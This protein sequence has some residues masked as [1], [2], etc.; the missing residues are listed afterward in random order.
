M[1]YFLLFRRYETAN[2][3]AIANSA[4]NPAGAG[5]GHEGRFGVVVGFVGVRVG[6]GVAVGAVT[7]GVTVILPVISM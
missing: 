4:S 5:V 7:N 2:N 3:P 6:L 1:F